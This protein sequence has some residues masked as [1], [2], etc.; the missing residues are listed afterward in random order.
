MIQY[1]IEIKRIEEQRDQLRNQFIEKMA[2][3]DA[4]VSKDTVLKRFYATPE[5][6]K[7]SERIEVLSILIEYLN[8]VK[9]ALGRTTD[10]IKNKIE[11]DKLERL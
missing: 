5:V 9:F 3:F 10:D 6:K 1:K 8:D 7:M 11:L 2:D 4:A